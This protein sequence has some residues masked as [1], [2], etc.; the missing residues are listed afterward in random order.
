MKKPVRKV[1]DNG[2]RIVVVPMPGS[3]TVTTVAF[4]EAGSRYE[5]KEINGISHFL[6]H[7][8][9]KGTKKRKKSIEISGELDALGAVSNAFTWYEYTGY[10]AK[11][12]ARYFQKITDVISDMFLNSQFPKEEI[13]KERGVIMAEIDM[14]EDLPQMSVEELLDVLMYG[15]QPAGWS[16]LGPKENIKKITQEDF[17]DYRAKNYVSKKTAVVVA[18]DVKPQDVFDEIE[19]KFKDI[20]TEKGLT[21]SKVKEDQKSKA[22]A[23]K[24]KNTD[25][26]HMVVGFRTF[27]VNN[28][29]NIKIKVLADVFGGSM[30]SR[31]FQSL[32][33]ELGVAYYTRSSNQAFTDTGVFGISAGVDPK[34][35]EEVLTAISKEIKDI[36][37]NLVTEKE[38]N[39]SKEHII[40]SLSMGLESSDKVAMWI[41]NMEMTHQEL[42]TPE[43]LIKEIKKVTAKD[44]QKMAQTIFQE[45]GMNLAI[46]GPHKDG[47]ELLKHLKV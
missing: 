36:K 20:S 16:V 9:F 46:V 26:T 35:I 8:F 24:Y 45:K 28:K 34:R 39:K 25:Q 44:V 32:R 33:E 3:P 13:E 22:V 40:G 37:T 29:N 17:F 19:L 14:Y 4:V 12:R 30:S 47:K 27:G 11:A 18:G 42:I 21:K 6:E 23:V 7:M 5:T 31:L 15:D 43:M 41:G 10:Y 1:L 38:L 2:M